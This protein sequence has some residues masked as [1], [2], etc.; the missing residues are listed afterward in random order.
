MCLTEK[1]LSDLFTFMLNVL[2]SL[3]WKPEVPKKL[4]NLPQP[5]KTQLSPYAG[6][7][8]KSLQRET[9]EA[10]YTTITRTELAFYYKFCYPFSIPQSCSAKYK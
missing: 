3:T 6:Q 10:S 1:Q 9:Q 4:D 2:S 7:K 5:V 8:F